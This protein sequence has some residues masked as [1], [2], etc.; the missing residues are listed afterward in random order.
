MRETQLVWLAILVPCHWKVHIHLPIDVVNYWLEVHLLVVYK[1]E[2]L[3]RALRLIR[4]LPR[5]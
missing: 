5:A 2:T 4:L 1:C 3:Y